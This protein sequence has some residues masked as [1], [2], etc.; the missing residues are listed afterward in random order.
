MIR[1][2]KPN[3]R[4]L[5]QSSNEDRK[6][7]DEETLRQMGEV[8][9]KYLNRMQKDSRF[10]FGDTREVDGVNSGSGIVV[11]RFEPSEIVLETTIGMGEFG[12]VLKV[13]TILLGKSSKHNCQS[14]QNDSVG[15][16]SADF[17]HPNLPS[18]L[19]LSS[20]QSHIDDIETDQSLRKQLAKPSTK[21]ND[22]ELTAATTTSSSPIKAYCHPLSVSQASASIELAPVSSSDV[23]DNL[24]LVI[25]QIRKDLYPKK[26][27]EAAKDLARE[28]KLLARLQQLYFFEGQYSTQHPYHHFN[29]TA[30][31]NNH[32]NIISLRGIVSDP[33]TREF[34][35][36]LDRL[37]F[38]LTELST[39][40]KKRQDLILETLATANLRKHRGASSLLSM[41]SIIPEQVIG[42]VVGV[43]QKVGGFL[44]GGNQER[45]SMVSS[46][47]FGSAREVSEELRATKETETSKRVS[48]ES[49][50]LLG[51]RILALWDVSEGMTHLHR[52]RILY[53]D[54]KTEN[55][56]RTIC[57]K[58]HQDNGV[59]SVFQS[60][61]HREQQRMQIFD[62]G[63][64]KECKPSYRVSQFGLGGDENN[65]DSND[66]ES[67]YENYKMTGM[68]GTM[69]IMAPEVIK[70]LPYGLPVD[71]YSFGICMWE[72]FTGKKC[73]FL[74]AAEICD[75]KTTVRPRLPIAFDAITER[76][77]VGMP[78]KLQRLMQ[79]CW[80][81]DPSK[82]PTFRE[83]SKTLRFCLAEVHRLS[84]DPKDLQQQPPQQQEPPQRT[85]KSELSPKRIKEGGKYLVTSW[86][87]CVNESRNSGIWSNVEK[88]QNPKRYQNSSMG[89]ETVDTTYSNNLKLDQA[90][91]WSRL[92]AIR[93]SGLLDD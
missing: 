39:S 18:S 93:A 66:E 32:P 42:A 27:I 58:L 77:S 75:T 11:P 8:T 55:V 56:G 35:I 61:D 48:P 9:S 49:L 2:T 7:R 36:L 89:G 31:R 15:N 50:L 19:W 53:R 16:D 73:N 72:V 12:V 28:A 82:R 33:G 91:F 86:R 5:F 34:G 90:E 44:K 65:I 29:N 78:K 83:I 26:G 43:T 68:T 1:E 20:E 80:H 41:A 38:T 25:K 81:E 52:H 4:S 6:K 54:L 10:F 71:V 40:W 79:R 57:S 62:F 92:E 3:Q 21:N 88:P 74:S 64:A 63:L 17:E 87:A 76:G 14:K 84:L 22:N 45:S 24:L 59:H 37:H 69:R 13:G 85:L 46:T 67:F 60:F 23:P 70:C 30:H 51:E 47:S